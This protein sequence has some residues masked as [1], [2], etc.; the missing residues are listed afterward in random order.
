[1]S[2][3]RRA[4]PGAGS[5]TGASSPPSSPHPAL[6]P[7]V[8]A[9]HIPNAELSRWGLSHAPAPVLPPPPTTAPESARGERANSATARDADNTSALWGKYQETRPPSSVLLAPWGS[10]QTLATSVNLSHAPLPKGHDL[11]PWR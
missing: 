6:P 4:A 1:M 11:T 8:S 9:C 2:A 5:L 3:R 7:S 10:E